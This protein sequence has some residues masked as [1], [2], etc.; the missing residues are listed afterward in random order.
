MARKMK[1]ADAKSLCEAMTIIADGN[2]YEVEGYDGI[3]F[4]DEA[5]EGKHQY[6]VRHADDDWSDLASVKAERGLTVNFWGTIVTDKPIDFAGQNE[7][8]INWWDYNN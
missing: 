5:I 3:Y 4:E 2:E 1:Y 6:Y 7:I 8:D